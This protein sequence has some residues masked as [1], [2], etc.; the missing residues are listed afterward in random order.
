MT[1]TSSMEET[2]ATIPVAEANWA[3]SSRGKSR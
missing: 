1:G 3:N 2:E